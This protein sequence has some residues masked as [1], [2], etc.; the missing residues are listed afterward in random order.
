M[1]MQLAQYKNANFILF[2]EKRE[3]TYFREQ[4]HGDLRL[5]NGSFGRQWK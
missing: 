1:D 4:S 5:R 3:C 2:F